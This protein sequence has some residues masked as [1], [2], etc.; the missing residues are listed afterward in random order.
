MAGLSR[1]FKRGR[2]IRHLVCY[3][4][5]H[6]EHD[7]GLHEGCFG[8]NGLWQRAESL[9]Q[10]LRDFPEVDV[11]VHSTWRHEISLDDIKSHMPFGLAERI[12]GL[13]PKQPYERLGSIRE[14]RAQYSIERFVIV[15]DSIGEF[16]KGL[17]E[18][19]PC[20]ECGLG[21]PNTLALLRKRLEDLCR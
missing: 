17:A 10:L 20:G 21:D 15:D 14:Y 2:A 4:A 5:E 19:L 8:S 18:L 7:L 3:T 9:I 11:V 12:V 16:P 13:T 6:L 1:D